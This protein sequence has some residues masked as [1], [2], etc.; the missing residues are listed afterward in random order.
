MTSGGRVVGEGLRKLANTL[1]T[2][3]VDAVEIAL[4]FGIY[5]RKIHK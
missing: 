2:R 1:A 5:G 3:L 4:S